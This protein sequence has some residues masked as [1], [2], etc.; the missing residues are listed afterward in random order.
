MKVFIG[1]LCA[2][3]VFGASGVDADE[4]SVSVMEGDS[5]TLNTGVNVTQKDR[6]RWYDNDTLIAQINGDLSKICTD[7][8]CDE[9]N[10]RFRDRLKLDHQTGSLTITNTRNT[11]SGEYK[12][13][14]SS[15]SV[16]S[17]SVD[18]TGVSD[19]DTDVFVMEGDSVTLH[20]DA[21]TNQ[22]DRVRWYFNETRIAQI[23]GDQSKI[24]TDEQCDE[25]FRN[26]LKLDHQT[27]SLT[28]TN[29]KA[30]DSG[31]YKLQ[32]SS[33]ISEKTFSVTVR[34]VP[35][36]ELKTV[37]EGEPVTLNP[38]AMK[39]PKDLLTWYFNEISIAE[40]T[41]GQSKICTDVQCDER[42]RDRLKLDNQ[43]GS[44]T[45]MNT[46]TTD[47]GE[48]KLEITSSR[49][50]I[51]RRRRSVRITSVK[52]FRVSVIDSGLPPGAVVGIIVAAVVLLVAAVTVGVIYGRSGSPTAVP[53][54]EDDGL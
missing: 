28:I 8:Q 53:Q 11:D 52:S 19:V 30:T 37:K 48:Y 1:I 7:V 5:V 45:I 33:S 21:K 31:R 41:G 16:K 15:R 3:V 44:L 10:E 54:N 51:Q 32:I 9:G 29:T 36:A 38:G 23:I 24:C 43:T 49:S 47:S 20:T 6:I 40:I 13:Q 17:F 46:R 12:L 26:R 27:G 25:R 34:D 18:V 35:A 22:Q 2:F 4:E 14:F 39:N 50:S 42:F